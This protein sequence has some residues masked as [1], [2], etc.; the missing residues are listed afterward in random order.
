M[1]KVVHLYKHHAIE[2]FESNDLCIL[3]FETRRGE[4]S[5]SGC[6]ALSREKELPLTTE[7]ETWYTVKCSGM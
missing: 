3:I 7:W 6:A 1:G 5:V 4:L 2:A